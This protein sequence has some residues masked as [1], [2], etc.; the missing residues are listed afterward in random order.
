M[1]YKLGK[2]PARKGAISFKLHDYVD[3]SG[4]PLVPL[5]IGHE[6][7]G[8]PWGMFKNDEYSCCVFAGAAHEHMIWAHEG[9]N[10]ALGFTD[11]NV[12]ADYAA[13]TGFDPKDADSDNGTDMAAAASYRRKTGIIDSAG[14]RHKVDTYL[15]LREGN[16]DDLAL[17]CYLSGGVGVGL[18]LPNA[19]MDQFD[20]EKPWVPVAKGGMAG[21]HYV[22]CLGRNTAGDFL[23]VSWGR[24][25]A[26]S[27]KFYAK[28]SD[29]AVCYL[30]LEVLRNEVSPEG[31]DLKSLKMHLAKLAKP[32]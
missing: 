3:R 5:R 13:V 31:F 25:Q 14:I 6:K 23:I 27:P 30:S 4:L 20:A 22:N 19:A 15:A 32:R 8:R 17:A 12:L 21:G 18:Q 29:E 7:I 24:I 2:R 1:L 11:E 10:N 28:Y 16:P 26:M 9:G